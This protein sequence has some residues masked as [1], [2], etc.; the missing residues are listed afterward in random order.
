VPDY[1]HDLRFGVFLTPSARDPEA[2]VDLAVAADDAGL[3][4]V[5]FQD[6]PYQARFLETW[7]LLSFVAA[8]TGRI[9]L[10]P[11]VLNLR[12]REPALV[13]R[14][15]ATLDLLSGGRIELGLGGGAFPDAVKGMGGDPLTPG[16]RLAALAE[17]IDVVHELLDT[18]RPGRAFFE[19]RHHRLY[20]AARG[21]ATTR[22][23]PIWV[24]GNGPR[25]LELVGR[26]ADGW[27]PSLPYLQPGAIGRANARID[28]AASAAGRDAASVRRLLNVP[29]LGA[30]GG[31][32][33]P[34]AWPDALARLAL[35]DGFSSFILMGDDRAAI[36]WLATDVA[37]RV[38]ERVATRRGR[39]PPSGP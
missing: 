12:L 2:V 3:D 15:A 17:A 35:E 36:D 7:T 23:I 6:H 1:G 19:G 37:P 20:G 39:Q 5:A 9:R 14:S 8:R 13:A 18:D 11:D 29:P 24:G 22:R 10:V 38:R 21:P 34:S 31:S 30:P 32:V 33:E 4:L 25:M 27:L 16:G 28:A 26:K